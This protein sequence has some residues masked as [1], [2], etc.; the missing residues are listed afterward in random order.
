MPRSHTLVFISIC[1]PGRA[2]EPTYGAV[3]ICH[4]LDTA[5]IILH[6][7]SEDASISKILG[8]CS[9]VK[10]RT[11]PFMILL[12]SLCTSREVAKIDVGTCRVIKIISGEF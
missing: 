2:P 9:R 5:A 1:I 6:M 7:L 12:A 3:R 11:S 4:S 10:V 8:S